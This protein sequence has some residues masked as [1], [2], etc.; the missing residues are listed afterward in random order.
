[1]TEIETKCGWRQIN[2]RVKPDVYQ[3]V[4]QVAAAQRKT[5]TGYLMGLHFRECQ[6]VD[7]GQAGSDRG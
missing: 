1:M 6:R 3:E 4:V 7:G 2:L 5:I